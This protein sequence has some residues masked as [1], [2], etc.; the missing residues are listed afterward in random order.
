M[1]HKT[2]NIRYFNIFWKASLASFLRKKENQKKNEEQQ[3]NKEEKNFYLTLNKS[4]SKL[5]AKFF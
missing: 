2:M 5:N 4:T 3:L 1:I